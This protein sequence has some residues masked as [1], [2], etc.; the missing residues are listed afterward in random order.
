[1]RHELRTPLNAVIGYSEM[2]QEDAEDEGKKGVVSDLEKIHAAGTRLLE[3]IDDI[4]NF[5]TIGSGESELNLETFDISSQIKDMVASIRPLVAGDTEKV[6]DGYLLVVDDNEINRNLLSRRLARQGHTITTAVN[7][8]QALEMI[9][10]E[11]FDVVLLDIMMPEMNGY[12][13][14]EYLK[15]DSTLRHIPVIMM[16]ALDEMDS[17]V[18]CIEMGAE[19]YLLKPF[20]PVLLRSRVGACLE[21]K[22]SHDRE[23][24]YLQQIEEEK[25][26]SDELLRV[27]LPGEIV[28][29][30]KETDSVKPRR[31]ENVAV[32]FTDIVGFTPYCD[33][34]P[35]E[36]VLSQLQKIVEAFEEIATRHQMEKIKTIGDAF[37]A[38]CGLLEPVDNPVL[39]C[40]KSGLEMIAAIQDLSTEWRVRVGIHTGPV[41]A[42][43]VGRRKYLYDIWGDAVNTAARMES[44][45]VPGAVTISRP[46]WQQI[47]SQCL[48]ESLGPVE[49]KGK[50]AMEMFRVD[51]LIA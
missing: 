9:G 48:G 50:G 28:E 15:R 25:K 10:V 40:V 14:L 33:A 21:K 17:V 4:I 35:P 29:E 34:H 31:C 7:G 18:R 2:L 37:M 20:D 49:I 11:N 27:I 51:G 43:V 12:Q 16:S 41:V 46:A 6:G 47:S 5:S 38:A 42:G 39:N 22:R 45:G 30:L 32:L 36:D 1:M 3:L 8:R 44:H 24:S 19:D 13:V 23:V 26:R